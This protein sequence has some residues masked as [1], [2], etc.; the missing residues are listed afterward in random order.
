[1]I[2]DEPEVLEPLNHSEDNDPKGLIEPRDGSI[3]EAWREHV[4]R[5]KKKFKLERFYNPGY[6]AC[7]DPFNE[8]IK[9]PKTLAARFERWIPEDF[10][11]HMVN[12]FGFLRKMGLDVRL[13]ASLAAILQGAEPPR[14]YK[15]GDIDLQWYDPTDEQYA[16]FKTQF[17]SQCDPPCVGSLVLN[18]SANDGME[19]LPDTFSDLPQMFE[20]DSSYRLSLLLVTSLDPYQTV[21]VELFIEN[22]S[23]PGIMHFLQ[24]NEPVDHPDEDNYLRVSAFT[25]VWDLYITRLLLEKDIGKVEKRIRSFE[26]R[27]PRHLEN[28]I[29]NLPTMQRRLEQYREEVP[30]VAELINR[31]KIME[32]HIESAKSEPEISNSQLLLNASLEANPNIELRF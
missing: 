9:D 12:V 5:V 4:N 2:D 27:F 6:G 30:F 15:P 7:V 8:G 19:Q 23:E 17:A 26:R 29:R 22:E 3:R 16:E 10:Q 32:D 25:A 31:L 21:E 24:E 20:E 14:S 1:M 13:V 28:I 18:P 11:G